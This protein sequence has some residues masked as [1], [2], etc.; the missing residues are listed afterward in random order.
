MVKTI[1]F[2][3]FLNILDFFEKKV[4]KAQYFVLKANATIILL[5][6]DSFHWIS[7]ESS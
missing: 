1:W 4:P 5:Y 3:R 6:F 7:G 2:T